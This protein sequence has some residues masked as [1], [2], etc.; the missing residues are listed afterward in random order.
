MSWKS[1]EGWSKFI[2]ICCVSCIAYQQRI[3]FHLLQW[4]KHKY[5]SCITFIWPINFR[6]CL[7]LPKINVPYRLCIISFIVFHSSVTVI[8]FCR[9]TWFSFGISNLKMCTRGDDEKAIHEINKHSV[10]NNG[11]KWH[12]VRWHHKIEIS[13]YIHDVIYSRCV[14]LEIS[15]R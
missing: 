7:W 13:A 4:T 14:Y 8:G 6:Q 3:L 12:L 2:F 1:T 5:Y 9:D 15:I 10:E 11:M